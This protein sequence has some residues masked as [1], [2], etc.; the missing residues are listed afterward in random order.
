MKQV[1]NPGTGRL[2]RVLWSTAATAV[3]LMLGVGGLAAAWLAGWHIPV[4]SGRTYM[5]VERLTRGEAFVT[6]TDPFFILFVGSDLR[7]GV[8]GARA[9]AIHVLGIN[10]ALK[11]GTMIDIP[12]DTCVNIPGRG[13]RKIN[14]AHSNGGLPLQAQTIDELMGTRIGYGVSVDFAGFS[15][16]VDSV[17]G[18]V[19]NVPTEMNDRY[20]GAYFQPGPQRLDSGQALAFSRNRHDFPRGDITRTENQGLLII[21]A[22]AQLRNEANS[23]ASQFRLAATLGR[24]A[25][26]DGLSVSDVFRLGRLAFDIDPAAIRNLTIPIGGNPP[27]AGGLSVPSSASSLFADFADDAVLQSN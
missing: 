19:V 2:R 11:A 17:G 4:A 3:V 12:R 6:P 18:V 25:Q 16:L 22:M 8:G 20:S 24:H 27:C 10:P 1:H 23:V 5:K 14:E 9:D 15:A 21:S 7:P 13:V 26:L